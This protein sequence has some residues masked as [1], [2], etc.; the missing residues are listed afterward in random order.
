MVCMGIIH[1]ILISK[2]IVSVRAAFWE[3]AIVSVVFR[4][5]VLLPGRA[6]ARSRARRLMR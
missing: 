6:F 4:L 5:W 3:V 1:F 2:H